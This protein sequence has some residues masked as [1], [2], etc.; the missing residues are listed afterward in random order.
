MAVN[1][2]PR[3]HHGAYLDDRRVLEHPR[4]YFCRD[5]D[6]YILISIAL[7]RCGLNFWRQGKYR[8]R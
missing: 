4:E 8:R 1:M 2:K 5:F 6:A 3:R 7:P